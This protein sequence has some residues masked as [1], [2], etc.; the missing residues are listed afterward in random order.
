[1]KILLKE[2][3]KNANNIKKIKKSLFETDSYPL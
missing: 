3:E 2:F 1:M